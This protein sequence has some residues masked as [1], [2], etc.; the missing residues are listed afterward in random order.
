M[1]L[2]NIQCFLLVAV[3]LS[4]QAFDPSDCEFVLTSIIAGWD[5]LGQ[6][7]GDVVVGTVEVIVVG[8]AEGTLIE[9]G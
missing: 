3:I 7:V 6:N 1:S 2:E 4:F 9:E 8:G 5:H